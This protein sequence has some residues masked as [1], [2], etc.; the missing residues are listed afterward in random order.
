MIIKKC[1]KKH[2]YDGENFNE[3]PQCNPE[4]LAKIKADYAR[5][6]SNKRSQGSSVASSMSS[7]VGTVS[8]S[9][10]E[11]FAAPAAPAGDIGETQAIYVN[12][13]NDVYSAPEVQAE[14]VAPVAPVAEPAPVVEVAPVVEPEPVIETAAPV[15]EA[16]PVVSAETV[17]D[18]TD[19]IV[20][21]F[22]PI[23]ASEL[24]V[25]P[26]VGWLICVGGPHFGEAF[27]I[28]VGEN[29]I[30]RI[31]DNKIVISKDSSVSRETH[32]TLKFDPSTDA[33]SIEPGFSSGLTYING[34]LAMMETPVSDGAEIELGNSK[35]VVKALCSDKFDWGKFIVGS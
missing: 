18:N 31:S 2:F 35:F 7:S 25:A 5:L 10:P 32:A 28:N 29:S 15:V 16:A 11:A 8:I 1:E 4:L 6:Y 33:F 17:S 30:G 26:V 12:P 14:P 34:D 19:E 13:V 21:G 3:C 20:T 9:T 24:T 22:P 23:K 27:P